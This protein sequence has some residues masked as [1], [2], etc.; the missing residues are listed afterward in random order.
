MAMMTSFGVSER[1]RISS[2]SSQTRMAYWP[3]PNTVTSP[4]PGS[5]ASLS[6]SEI[7]A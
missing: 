2:G 1:S 3:M 5:R 7:V 4:T 6:L